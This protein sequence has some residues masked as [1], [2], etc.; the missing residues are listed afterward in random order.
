MTEEKIEGICLQAIPYLEKGRILKVFT[1][2][3]GLT[4][5]FWKK[6]AAPLSPFCHAECVV[7]KGKGEMHT[8]VEASL[9]DPFLE[10]RN[11]YASLI[12]AGKIAKD[13]LRSQ[14][15]GKSTPALYLLL[16]SYFKKIGTFS[17]PAI[18]STSF[19]LKLLLH[20]G[21][22]LLEKEYL[23]LFDQEE[24]LIMK[25]LGCLP[26]F[27]QLSQVLL[28]T[29]LEEKIDRFFQ[30]QIVTVGEQV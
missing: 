15:L 26:T 5:L 13:L 29:A 4:T 17:N 7:K 1:L 14:L 28:P 30:K 19:Q 18:L 2:Q 20:E 25:N 16:L 11:S 22:L 8:L 10:M 3:S 12:K 27:S 21:L 6:G 24:F 23:P 9:L